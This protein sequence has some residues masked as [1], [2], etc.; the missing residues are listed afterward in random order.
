MDI[1][2]QYRQNVAVF[3]LNPAGQILIC[4]RCDFPDTWQIPQGGIDPGETAE[5]AM[6]RELNEE[7][8]TSDVSILGRLPRPIRYEWPEALYIR[9][10]RGQEQYYFLVRLGPGASLNLDAHPHREFRAVAWTGAEDF[11]KKIKGFKAPAYEQ[12]ML[13][14]R[15]LFPELIVD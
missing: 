13:E 11:L 4:E 8:G 5:T 10:Y 6:I 1:P 14:F 9:G 2:E 3:V 12:A 7:I 15:R